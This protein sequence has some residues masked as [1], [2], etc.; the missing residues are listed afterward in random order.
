MKRCVILGGGDII[1]YE[2]AAARLVPDD[3]IICADSGYHHCAPL[4]ITPDLLVGDFDSIGKMPDGVEILRY[5]TDKDYTDTGLAA[6]YALEHR[7][8]SI[9]LLG[10]TGGGRIEHTLA[11][12]QTAAHCAAFC[13]VSLYDGRSN[14]TVIRAN[15][16]TS[17]KLQPLDEHYFSLLA[18]SELCRDVTITGGKYPLNSYNLRY[19][20]ARAVS[21][22]FCGQPV[23]ISFESGTLLVVVTPK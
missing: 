11:N 19:D 23:T 9:L 18:F 16:P 4:D 5:R 10:M 21:N 14:I 22:E 12:L 7:F 3:F 6:E 2:S 17:R 15:S 8:E 13:E 20:E 1:C